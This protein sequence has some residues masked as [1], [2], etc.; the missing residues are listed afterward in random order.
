MEPPDDESD[1]E[2]A[3]LLE[4]T[5]ADHGAGAPRARPSPSSS[6]GAASAKK[7][8][9]PSSDA[10]EAS[11][12]KSKFFFRL[13]MVLLNLAGVAFLF[14]VVNSKTESSIESGIEGGETYEVR[15]RPFDKGG[16]GGGS[17]SSASSSS[18][19]NGHEVIGFHDASLENIYGANHYHKPRGAGYPV[20]PRGGLH[21][22]YMIDLKEG[23][24]V[25]DKGTRYDADDYELSP[26]ADV[27]LKMTDE[28]RETEKK[29]WREH[30]KEIRERY[31]YWNFVDEYKSKNGGKSRPV[32][33]WATVGAKKQNY[34]PLLGEI[35]KEDFPKGSWQADD[36]YVAS[37]LKEGKSL[38]KRV[39]GAISEEYGWETPESAGGIQ[40]PDGTDVKNVGGN[41]GLAWMYEKSF[42]ALAKKLLNAMITNDHFFVTLGGHSAAAGHGA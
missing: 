37:L 4:E 35:D 34:N 26:Y 19:N 22:V 33:D 38:V 16:K 18:P 13:V 9:A 12:S 8:G 6:N 1:L 31:G 32:V 23:E 27:R 2:L 28:E 30:L 20:A 14:L 7:L 25:N 41:L 24:E 3:S 15:H 39:I 29:E 11:G 42:E 17:P 21:P 40:I 36:D 5:T 10:A